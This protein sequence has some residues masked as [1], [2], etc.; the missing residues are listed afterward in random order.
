VTEGKGK[1]GNSENFHVEKKL[2]AEW[3]TSYNSE[4]REYYTRKGEKRLGWCGGQLLGF[5]NTTWS[6]VQMC[7]QSIF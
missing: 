4:R 3:P 1:F 6:I 2:N 7:E 5:S